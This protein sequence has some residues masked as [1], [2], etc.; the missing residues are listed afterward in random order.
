MKK[1]RTLGAWKQGKCITTGVLFKKEMPNWCRIMLVENRFKTKGDTKPD[2][3][4]YFV[5]AKAN[6]DTSIAYK[7]LRSEKT[8]IEDMT[9]DD[10][11]EYLKDNYERYEIEPALEA[12]GII[13]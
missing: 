10:I 5:E 9:L 12:Y 11:A 7:V 1:T 3:V 6:V 2:Y 4:G 13:D 8:Y